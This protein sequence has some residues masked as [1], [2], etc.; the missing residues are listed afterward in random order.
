MKTNVL[1]TAAELEKFF[2][3][4]ADDRVQP[5]QAEVPGAPE[6]RRCGWFC[7]GKVFLPDNLIMG[8]N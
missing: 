4:P 1:I 6:L 7:A 5:I 2:L 3:R 8:V